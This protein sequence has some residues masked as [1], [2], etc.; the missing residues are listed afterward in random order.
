[1]KELK[2]GIFLLF[3]VSCLCF[4]CASTPDKKIDS[5]FVM[6]YDYENSGVMD[7]KVYV[8]GHLKGST[9]VYGR[10]FF[11]TPTDKKS[12]HNIKVEKNGYE[13]SE[14]TTLLCDGQVLYFK[15]GNASY[16]AEFAEKL[17]DEGQI[18]K[19]LNMIDKALLIQDREDYRY[20]Q[21]VIKNGV[22]K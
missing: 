13:V 14:M 20:L 21:K 2:F 18:S 7:V 11:P 22:S 19:A 8:D 10:F 12:M 16:Y 15:I 4:S 5:V 1:M 9:D 17:F 3:A 6:I